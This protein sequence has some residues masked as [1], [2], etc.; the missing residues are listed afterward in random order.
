MSTLKLLKILIIIFLFIVIVAILIGGV[1]LLIRSRLDNMVEKKINDIN[2]II[3][4]REIGT[5]FISPPLNI[6]Y[7]KF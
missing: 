1:Y 5:E 2:D 6:I 7:F 4:N 3:S